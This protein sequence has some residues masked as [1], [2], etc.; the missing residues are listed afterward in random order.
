MQSF[1]QDMKYAM[2]SLHNAPT[3]AII[4]VVTLGLGMAVNTTVFSIVNGLLLRP[5]PVPHP[6]QITV[7]A[8]KQPGV[9]GLQGFSYPDFQD[10]HSQAAGSAE[11]F[12]YRT[13]LVSVISEGKGDHC[14]VSRVTGNYFSA[15][16]IKPEIGRLILPTEG[17]SPGAD[18]VLVL[19][20]GFWQ[21]RFGGD[22][23]IV[24]K[25]VEVD[26]HGVTIIGVT[27][28]DFQGTYAFLRMDGFIPLSAISG[29]GGSAPVEETWTDRAHRTIQLMARLKPGVELTQA[30][31]TLD[32]IGKRLAEQHTETDKGIAVQIF[33]ERLARPEP[34]PDNTIPNVALAFTVLAGL[35]LLVACFNIANVLLVRATVRQREMAIRAAIGAGR[36]RLVRQHLT[37][38]LV[39]AILGGAVGLLLGW[40]ASGFLS[41]LSLGT[42]LPVTFNF[43]PD[44]RVYLFTLLA[45]L[46]TGAV[47]GIMPALRVARTDVNSML[48]E[49]GRSGSDGP[50]R[51][52]VRST[53]VMAQVAGSLLLL[54]V[55]GLFVRSA[56][57]ARQIGLGFDP[58]NVVDVPIDVKQIGYTD[59]QGK[60]FYREAEERLRALPGVV[61]VGQAFS[62]P[63]G[64]MSADARLSVEGHPLQPGQPEP[65]V[66]YNA[67][68]PDYFAALRIPLRR[69]RAFTEA[70]SEKAAQ[71]AIV[72]EAMARRFWPNEDALGKRFKMHEADSQPMEV[73]GVVPDGKY[74]GIV[75]DPV[76]H[77][78]VPIEQHY[79]PL[80]TLH[81][82]TSVP[83][84]SL[85]LQIAAQVQELA[86]TLP[87]AGVK[88]LKQE[89]EGING[90]LFFHL[91]AQLTATMGVLGLI[92]AVVGVYSVVSYAAVQRTHEIGI[93][94]ALGAKPADILKMVLGQSLLIIG[95]GIV[96]GLGAA[97]A[98][99]RVL[100][101]LL[102]G[103]KATDPLTFV[104]VVAVLAGVALLACWLPARRATHVSPLVA[105]R[106]E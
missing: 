7:L 73:V 36:A 43:Q 63:L 99:T 40:W 34:D 76:P 41:S 44:A 16:G 42:D 13:S 30:A 31:A 61:S 92:L 67:V 45:V 39:L 60:A 62:V 19:G 102:V 57:K 53:L 58:E 46:L 95:I 68:S 27:P 104:V 49:G 38:S 89:L 106:Y 74:K 90:Y 8:M 15:L 5:L 83:P 29:L 88:T 54:I 66:Q 103:V 87:L 48:R 81:V 98:G 35:V 77:F 97:L 105:L 37:E 101:S 9:E 24:G 64:L 33:P 65:T 100:T 72:N 26:G 79:M 11:V 21:R 78:Y 70:D 96:I 84:E 2:R 52:M 75:E 17:Q 14:V 94:M 56:G 12:G 6:E 32:V 28:K 23:G 85:E 10:I 50:R 1:W 51:Q 22:Q 71:V 59:Q 91:G 18:P 69:G 4:A 86:P 80:R 3:F 82:R 55:A 25:Q 47:V 20:Y 93:R